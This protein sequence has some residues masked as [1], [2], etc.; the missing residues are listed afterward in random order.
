MSLPLQSLIER[1]RSHGGIVLPSPLDDGSTLLVDESCKWSYHLTAAECERD[2]ASEA[3][4]AFERSGCEVSSP[5]AVGCHLHVQVLQGKLDLEH[6]QRLGDAIGGA[7][8]DARTKSITLTL[9]KTS[10]TSDWWRRAL[11]AL[12]SWVSCLRRGDE[13]VTACVEGNLTG[14]VPDSVANRIASGGIRLRHVCTDPDEDLSDERANALLLATRTGLRIPVVFYVAAGKAEAILECASKAVQASQYSGLS[15]RPIQAHPDYDP[16]EFG[17]AI[18]AQEYVAALNSIYAEFPYYDDVF[19]PIGDVAAQID[20]AVPVKRR[21]KLL[22]DRA[23]RVGAFRKLPASGHAVRPAAAPASAESADVPP[24]R[25][26][27]QA[28]DTLERHSRCGPCPWLQV[29]GG[30]DAKTGAGEMIDDGV[31]DT[32]CTSWRFA[33]ELL[34][35]ERHS[36]K[37]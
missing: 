22:V 5:E 6:V 4:V 20:P 1:L 12:E 7:F 34:M 16:A 19:E 33:A 14:S 10:E 8:P 13:R 28:A 15:F 24:V 21:F 30:M 18:T 31:F 3:L 9:N 23:G 37:Q 27:R 35:W 11:P 32:S 29:C 25:E 2:T 26:L 17:E 36:F